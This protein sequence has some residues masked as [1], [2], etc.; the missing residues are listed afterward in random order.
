MNNSISVYNF[1]FILSVIF[2]YSCNKLE[3][4]S[5]IPKITYKGFTANIVEEKG[6]AVNKQVQL[7]FYILDG[8]G[9]VGLTEADTV[10]PF[11]DSLASN[12]LQQC[13]FLNRAFGIKIL[14]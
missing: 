12:F 6:V 10:K 1:M 13:M 14:N 9:D 8:D 7:H 4:Y 3:K 2:L 5:E 11:T